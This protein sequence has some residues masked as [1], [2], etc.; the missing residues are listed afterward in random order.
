M[1]LSQKG[2]F[3]VKKKKI[4]HIQCKEGKGILVLNSLLVHSSFF[5]LS[6]CAPVSC[7]RLWDFNLL[8]LHEFC[9]GDKREHLLSSSTGCVM[10]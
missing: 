5:L 4:W 9:K 8:P 10:Q 7:Y 1:S 2:H 6:L 3:L